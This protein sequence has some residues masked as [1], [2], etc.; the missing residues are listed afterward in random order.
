MIQVA[1]G[2]AKAQPGQVQ[3]GNT[4]PITHIEAPAVLFIAAAAL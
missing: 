3:H 2:A 4:P 1:D